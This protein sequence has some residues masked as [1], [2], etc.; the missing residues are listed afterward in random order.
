MEDDITELLE[1]KTDL[2]SLLDEFKDKLTKKK[3]NIQY[4]KETISYKD[5]EGEKKELALRK[6]SQS[7]E[8]TKKLLKSTE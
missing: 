2:E 1:C 3:E 8:E 7:A 4:L 5:Q 6:I